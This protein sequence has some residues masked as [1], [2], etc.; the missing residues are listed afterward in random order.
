MKTICIDARLWGI[1]HTGIGR[2]VENLI[3]HLPGSPD[4]RVVL[5]VS[6]SGLA[7]PKIA[8]FEKYVAH[9]HPYSPLAQTEMLYLLWKIRPHLTHFTH[10]SVPVFWFGKFVVTIHD[11]IK[12]YSTGLSTTTHNPLFY[13]LKYLGYQYVMWHAIHRSAKVIV[14]SEYWRTILVQKYMV[15]LSK[16]HVT[17]E[18][19]P[20][21]F[22]HSRSIRPHVDPPKPFVVYTGNLYPHK[23]VDTL[24][25]AV[26][27]VN[28][29][30]PKPVNLAIVCARSV[31]EDRLP[32][33]PSVTYLGRLSD[34]DLV[35]LYQHAAAFVFPSLI[36]GF[37]LPGLEAM[38][39]G[40]PVIA[41]WASC[42]PE[43]YGNAALYFD[44]LNPTDLAAKISQV[45]SDARL[46]RDLVRKG[47]RQ[48]TKYS[49]RKMTDTTWQI[50]HSVLL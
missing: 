46:R 34:N 15:P 12:S 32:R 38:A 40:C 16:I 33:S 18:G 29:T 41:A 2:Y 28:Q 9:F 36:E 7:E 30:G 42:L 24:I 11:L 21:H 10:F 47:L 39:V 17:Y 44:P 26:D 20:D 3:D 48:V 50:Y 31:F 35:G 49:W 22:T 5:I 43:V 8:K 37:G 1:S 27:L 14:P 25:K 19:V 4:H 45:L 23:N 6:P 13:W